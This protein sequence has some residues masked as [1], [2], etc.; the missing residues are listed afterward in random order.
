MIYTICNY[1][2]AKAIYEHIYLSSRFLI[3]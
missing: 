2:T 3:M 1:F